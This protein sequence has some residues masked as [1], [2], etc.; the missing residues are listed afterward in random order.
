MRVSKILLVFH[1][2]LPAHPLL[3]PILVKEYKWQDKMSLFIT[4]LILD[5]IMVKAPILWVKILR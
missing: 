4:V 5:S 3:R 2:L 1:L